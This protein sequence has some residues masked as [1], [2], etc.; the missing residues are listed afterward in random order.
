MMNKIG[1]YYNLTDL[2]GKVYLQLQSKYVGTYTEIS[3]IQNAFR[4]F[5]KELS[6]V[7]IFVDLSH[8]RDHLGYAQ[9]MKAL[10]D[11]GKTS[12]LMLRSKD[13]VLTTIN[14]GEIS[15]SYEGISDATKED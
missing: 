11:A 3:D 14:D 8:V 1:T 2:D 12:P 7:G 9:M 13:F 10:G 6:S 4:E 5:H 15:Y